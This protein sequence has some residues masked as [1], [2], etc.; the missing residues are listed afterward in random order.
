MKIYYAYSRVSGTFKDISFDDLK[1][2]M[3]HSK[4][5][6]ARMCEIDIQELSKC[7][8]FFGL[9]K[10]QYSYKRNNVSKK[11]QIDDFWREYE[12]RL[13]KQDMKDLFDDLEKN[14]NVNEYLDV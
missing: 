3:K 7:V 14:N 8:R 13:Y 11:K 2:L 1:R 6:A 5:D 10:W 9:S 12:D 4:K